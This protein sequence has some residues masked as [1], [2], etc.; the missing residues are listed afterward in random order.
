MGYLRIREN[1]LLL[2]LKEKLPG[3][4]FST[5]TLCSIDYVTEGEILLVL[6]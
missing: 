4:G 1:Q 5:Q 2:R 3:C 6:L